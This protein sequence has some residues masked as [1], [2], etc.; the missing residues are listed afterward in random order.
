MTGYRDRRLTELAHATCTSIV[1]GLLSVATSH[2]DRA[3][4]R[5]LS[6]SR[7]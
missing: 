2:L 4:R 3:A 5:K 7:R 1:S 6:D